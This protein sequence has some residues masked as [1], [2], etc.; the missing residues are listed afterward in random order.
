MNSKAV[1]D[2]G[3]NSIKFHVAEIDDAGCIRTVLDVL[4][5]ARLGEGLRET[6]K[7]SDEAADRNVAAVSRFVR[8]AREKG[9]D[10]VFAVGTMALRNAT[11]S[12]SFVEKVLA[13]CGVQVEIVPGKEEARFSYLAALSGLETIEGKNAVFDSGGGSTEIIA[14]TGRSIALKRSFNIG[15]VVVTEEFLKSN[16]VTQ[17]DLNAATNHIRAVLEEENQA[18]GACRIVGIGGTATTMGAVKHRM[19]TYDPEVIQGSKLT[20]NDVDNQIAAYLSKT[21]EERK[22]ITGLHPKRADIIL[23]GACIVRA[24]LEKFRADF[25]T[26]SDRGLR[27]GMIFDKFAKSKTA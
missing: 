8:V 23:A 17:E 18:P 9:V 1:I 4:D 5:Q 22:T 16:P 14:G 21:V 6:G 13:A 25:L 19:T 15:A 7:I 10:E 26:I 2:I 20:I 12:D 3:T 24:L 27:H 11:N